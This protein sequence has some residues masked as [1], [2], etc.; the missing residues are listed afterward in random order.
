MY[1]YI[2]WFEK[3]VLFIN[4]YYKIRTVVLTTVKLM[5]PDQFGLQTQKDPSHKWKQ[6]AWE[7]RGLIPY[8]SGQSHDIIRYNTRLY[9]HYPVRVKKKKQFELLLI[10]IS[11]L[12]MMCL[13]VEI[14]IIL[15]LTVQ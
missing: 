14:V 2:T 9:S 6:R 15:I 7:Y 8:L 3:I 12:E 13:A 5:L 10:S 4:N 11:N 1:A